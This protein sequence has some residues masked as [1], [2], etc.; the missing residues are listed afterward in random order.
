MNWTIVTWSKR[1]PSNVSRTWPL[2]PTVGQWILLTMVVFIVV[3][4]HLCLCV[5][6]MQNPTTYRSAEWWPC[7]APARTKK[8]QTVAYSLTLISLFPASNHTRRS[9]C[10]ISIAPKEKRKQRKRKVC[11]TLYVKPLF[12]YFALH[13]EVGGAFPPLLGLCVVVLPRLLI[14][15]SWTFNIGGWSYKKLERLP[16]RYL[17]ICTILLSSLSELSPSL[18]WLR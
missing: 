6:L 8:Y 4:P 17:S 2:V 16:A 5:R 10:S 18:V 12:V 3:S 15:H 13:W 1:N 7:K 9:W 11:S 14:K